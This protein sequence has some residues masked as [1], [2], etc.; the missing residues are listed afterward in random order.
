MKNKKRFRIFNLKHILR[1]EILLS[2]KKEGKKFSKYKNDLPPL[3][4]YSDHHENQVIIDQEYDN[5]VIISAK[6][7]IR[8]VSLPR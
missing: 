6:G 2:L 4:T 3:K 1:V 7:R 5:V 8:T